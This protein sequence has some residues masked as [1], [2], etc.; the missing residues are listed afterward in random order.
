MSNALLRVGDT[1]K[2]IPAVVHKVS[3][4]L[5]L[6]M[7]VK[8]ILVHLV[9]HHFWDNVIPRIFRTE[10]GRIWGGV[11]IVCL[12]MLP[13]KTESQTETLIYTEELTCHP[14]RPCQGKLL[15]V[16]EGPFSTCRH[17]LYISS[18]PL[19]TSGPSLY[20]DMYHSVIPTCNLEFVLY[21]NNDSKPH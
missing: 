6:R 5:S 21:N 4:R 18:S 20:L 10:K 12:G 16:L 8:L 14:V 9:H 15:E 7:V 13:T 11:E 1:V 19:A 17:S 2:T 3:N